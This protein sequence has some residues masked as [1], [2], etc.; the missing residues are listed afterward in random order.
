VVEEI[1]QHQLLRLS[2]VELIALLMQR[3][4]DRITLSADAICALVDYLASRT[5]LIR[6][7]AAF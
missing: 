2:D 5:S 7:M 6:D 4:T 3:V 1:P